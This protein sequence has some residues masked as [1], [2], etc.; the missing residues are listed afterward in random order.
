MG[1]Y[2]SSLN[3]SRSRSER[4]RLRRLGRTARSRYSSNVLTHPRGR[5]PS[6]GEP[7][8]ADD[9][10]RKFDSGGTQVCRLIAGQVGG[11]RGCRDADY[12]DAGAFDGIGGGRRRCELQVVAN[13]VEPDG[14]PAVRA[15]LHRPADGADGRCAISRQQFPGGNGFHHRA[16]HPGQR[17]NLD[18]VRRGLSDRTRRAGDGDRFERHGRD[19]AISQ[20]P[21]V[22]VGEAYALS[23]T[24]FPASSYAIRQTI[25][26]VCSG[27][28]FLDF[29]ADGNF[30]STG[31]DFWLETFIDNSQTPVPPVSDTDAPET[32]ITKAPTDRTKQ[33]IAVFEF[34]S[35]EPGSTFQCSFDGEPFGACTLR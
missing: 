28:P 2:P 26:D 23:I 31:G 10:T 3:H 30:T 5:L 22:N 1:E 34:A 35:S 9:G 18:L 17:R 15:D 20:P 27:N 6:R 12:S 7:C 24:D 25:G 11:S 14:G 32:T 21:A 13:R 19:R 4:C 33:K 16:A 8:I 29:S